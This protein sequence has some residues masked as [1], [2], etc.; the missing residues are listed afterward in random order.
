MDEDEERTNRLAQAGLDAGLRVLKDASLMAVM[1]AGEP[2]WEVFTHAVGFV[3]LAGGASGE[4]VY[5]WMAMKR[6]HAMPVDGFAK[7]DA[8]A[9]LFFEGFAATVTALLPLVMPDP[10]RAPVIPPSVVVPPQDRIGQRAA[11]FDERVGER[12]GRGPM[13]TAEV[14]VY[15]PPERVKETVATMMAAEGRRIVGRKQPDAMPTPEE[16]A[17]MPPE[18]RR[19]YLHLDP[20]FAD[21]AIVTSAPS[22]DGFRETTVRTPYGEGTVLVPPDASD[23]P[24]RMRGEDGEGDAQ[25]SLSLPVLPGGGGRFTATGEGAGEAAIG[26]PATLGSPQ[27]PAPD[28][29][30]LVAE[31]GAGEVLGVSSPAT[32]DKR[33]GKA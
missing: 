19:A 27:P 21:P 7:L 2:V 6:L 9:R 14:K 17:S 22:M 3:K 26:S 1:F 5:R 15:V 12:E 11:R 13:S 30:P 18:Q 16:M 4:P 28:A 8:E 33:R 10:K 29:A 24:H 32:G 31:D 20:R 23:A 25:A